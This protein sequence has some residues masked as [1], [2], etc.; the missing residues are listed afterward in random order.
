MEQQQIDNVRQSDYIIMMFSHIRMF[1]LQV[2]LLTSLIFLY[3]SV[4]LSLHI[5]FYNTFSL[6][7]S[8]T[9]FFIL[10][11]LIIIYF[12]LSI[13]KQNENYNKY[14]AAYPDIIKTPM[15]K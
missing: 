8:I 12:I 9:I 10:K 7:F 6:I 14:R 15:T 3:A 4:L 5:Y 11:I 2:G 13:K 1:I